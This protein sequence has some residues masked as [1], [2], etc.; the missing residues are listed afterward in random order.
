MLSMKL[1]LGTHEITA[2]QL[3]E[4]ESLVFTFTWHEPVVVHNWSLGLLSRA[5]EQAEFDSN[6][7]IAENR[8]I[9]MVAG[10][11]A[12]KQRIDTQLRRQA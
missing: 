6:Y 2:S 5:A 3:E 8:F 12:V 1:D 11:E 4:S 7:A 9:R 10:P